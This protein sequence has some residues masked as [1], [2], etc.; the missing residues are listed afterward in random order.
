M[1]YLLSLCLLL[2]L[3]NDTFAQGRQIDLSCE[4][5]DPMPGD[6]FVSPGTRN[7]KVL[8]Y[9][10]GPDTLQPMDEYSV[11]FTF[12]AF[13]MFPEFKKF[14]AYLKPGYSTVYQRIIDVDYSG[15]VAEM[16]FCAEAYAYRIGR[17]SIQ[18]EKKESRDNNKHCVTTSHIDS[19][20][21]S[22]KEMGKN[23]QITLFPNPVMSNNVT[24]HHKHGC[25][26]IEVYNCNAQLARSQFTSPN[27]IVTTVDCE[28]LIPGLYYIQV[29]GNNGI[30]RQKFIVQQHSI[31]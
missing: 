6:S 28:G 26:K 12:S 27:S 11:K 31:A 8:I 29:L 25:S 17:D 3:C 15:D 10:N 1:K 24:V 9:N 23:F 4:I 21:N 18:Q 22:T 5:V 16:Q 19:N 7:I 14:N 30:S 2:L 20:I 13:H